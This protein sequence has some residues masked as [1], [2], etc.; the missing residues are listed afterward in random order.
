MNRITLL[1]SILLVA[2][3]PVAAQEHA[4]AAPEKLGTV[5]FA[6][7]CNSSVAPTFDRAVALLHSFETRPAQ[8]RIGGSR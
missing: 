1:V 8:S 4:H 5:H 3:A 6:T 7:S 2:A